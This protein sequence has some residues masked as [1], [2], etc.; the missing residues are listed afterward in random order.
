M[1]L[2]NK[3]ILNKLFNI[4][5]FIKGLDSFLEVI[6]GILLFFIRP[7]QISTFFEFIFHYE[8]LEDPHDLVANFLINFSSNLF[9]KT[10]LFLAIYLFIHGIIKLGLIIGLW[11]KKLWTY[12]TAEIVFSIFVIYQ[13][14]RY[15]ISNSVYLLGLTILDLVVIT[16]TWWEYNQLKR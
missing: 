13:I 16:L 4:S 6:G 3:K 15:T 10:E 14:Y 7:E 11:K 9:I 8:L 12:I 5:I 2:L 1:Q